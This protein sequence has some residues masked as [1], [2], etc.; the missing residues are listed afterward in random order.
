L[1]DGDAPRW[2]PEETYPVDAHDVAQAIQTS[3]ALN[4]SDWADRHV[5]YALENLYLGEGLFCYKHFADGTNH[6]A[7]FIRWTQAPMYKA[8]AVYHALRD[9]F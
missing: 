8:L 1:L 6:P 5:R 4:K 7:N 2:S 3:L 9:E